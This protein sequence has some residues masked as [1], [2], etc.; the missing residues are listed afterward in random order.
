MTEQVI[1][2]Q[3]EAG[4]I[5]VRLLATFQYEDR[6]Y[7]YLED[8]LSKEA[9]LFSYYPDQE[10]FVFQL[11]EDQQ[12]W[13]EASRAYQDLV[14]QPEEKQAEKGNDFES[15]SQKDRT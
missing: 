11:V 15:G 8:P 1:Q 6:Q 4:P 7:C 2:I 13:D 14:N 5:E 12:E 9:T 10:D 3:G